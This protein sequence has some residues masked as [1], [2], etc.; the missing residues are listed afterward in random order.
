MAAQSSLRNLGWDFCPG[1]ANG[2]D[3]VEDEPGPSP[4]QPPF[5]KSNKPI[6]FKEAFL[7]LSSDTHKKRNKSIMGKHKLKTY[8]KRKAVTSITN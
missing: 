4:P 8:D 1:S 5:F 3:P 2:D 7:Q 6:I